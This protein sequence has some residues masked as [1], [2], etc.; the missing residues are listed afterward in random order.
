[1]SLYVYC[2][3]DASEAEAFDGAVGLSNAPVSIL[4]FGRV[5]AIVGDLEE[6]ESVAATGDNVAAHNLV[7]S[8]SLAVATPL[9]SRFG[10]RVS[11]ARLAES[12]AAN[13]DALVSA[14]ARVRGCVEMGVKIR[15]GSANAKGESQKS[16]AGSRNAKGC[17]EKDG[18]ARDGDARVGSGTAFLLAKQREILGDESL[19]LRAEELAAWLDRRMSGLAR[20]SAVRLRPSES[21]VVR[22]AHLVERGRVAEYRERVR[23]LGDERPALQF[24]T[25]GPW[26]PYSFSDI[27][28]R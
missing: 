13:E 22:A 5:A 9:P 19:K 7:C 8:R 20:E 14:L 25:S 23:S 28:S 6:G 10:A 1:M 21:L 11:A 15:D 4:K 17:R 16:K 12:V 27:E 2:L 3:C 24:L 26:P 18:D